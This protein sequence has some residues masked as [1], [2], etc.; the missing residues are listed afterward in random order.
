[1][2]VPNYVL[3]E[4]I[5]VEE[6]NGAGARGPTYSPQRSIR[7]LMQPTNRLLTE[8]DGHVVTIDTIMI[9]RPES[10]LLPVQSRVTWGGDNYRVL[11]AFAMPDTRR[12]THLEYSLTRLES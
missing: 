9:A 7:A 11:R 12:P 4:T 5:A 6:Y 8:Q 3:R 1:M 2:R 10:G